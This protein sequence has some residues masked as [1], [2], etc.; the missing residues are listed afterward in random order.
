M[1]MKMDS[2]EW[3]AAAEKVSK[4]RYQQCLDSLE[5]LIDRYY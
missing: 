5:A 2:P 1:E 3:K 4:R